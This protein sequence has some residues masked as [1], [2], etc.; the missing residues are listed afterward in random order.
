MKP[1]SRTRAASQLSEPLLHQLNLY[2]LAATTAGVASLAL[3]E[4]ANAKIVY[5][6]AHIPIVVN[7]GF[8]ELDLNH[9][10]VNDFKFQNI[11]GTHQNAT[12]NV[13]P[14]QNL[15]RVWAASCSAAF[16]TS[17]CAAALQKGR[18]IGP[19]SSFQK[20]DASVLMA[21]YEAHTAQTGSYFGEWTRRDAYL[22]LK[23]IVKGKTHFGW[24]RVR[25]GAPSKG[26]PA[27]IT[28][29]AYETIPNKPIIT[30][31]TKGPERDPVSSAS[32]RLPTRK[33][34]TLDLLALGS[35][36]QSVW[37]RDE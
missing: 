5:T 2:A 29:Y 24:A 27:T 1:A 18:K 10:G 25:V 30:G 37:R 8:I 28:G 32:L 35:P 13:A 19:G 33:P 23:F 3:V 16:N 26:F 7:G 22:G 9:D 15:N 34:A 12:L 6:P 31:K 36:G 21:G 14:A 4:P 17:R 11:Y 20:K